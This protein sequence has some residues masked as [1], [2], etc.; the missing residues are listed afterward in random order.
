MLHVQLHLLRD[1]RHN[2]AELLINM[3]RKWRTL[4]PSMEAT[5]RILP[6]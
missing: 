4:R 6:E 2:R 1:T 3:D 5:N